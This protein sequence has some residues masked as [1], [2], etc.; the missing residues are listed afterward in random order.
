MV[1]D[2]MI[3]LDET[4]KYRSSNLYQLYIF[5]TNSLTIRVFQW[6]IAFWMARHTKFIIGHLWWLRI[7][8][9]TILYIWLYNDIEYKT[10]NFIHRISTE[11]AISGSFFHFGQAIWRRLWD[12][13]LIMLFH[14]SYTFREAIKRISVLPLVTINWFDL[15]W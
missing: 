9:H 10:Y 6:L 8:Y 1:R 14:I 2:H 4:F 13:G 3:F 5:C 7:S 11:S 12:I 15:I